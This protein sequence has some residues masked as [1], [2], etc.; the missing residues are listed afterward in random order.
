MDAGPARAHCFKL[1]ASNIGYPRIAELAG[2]SP[3]TVQQLCAGVHPVIR[4]DTAEKLL[5]VPFKP[6]LGT[7][8][9]AHDTWRLLRLLEKEL[10]TPAQIAGLIGAESRMRLGRL[11]RFGKKKA[12][13]W[14]TFCRLGTSL[15]IK[16]A[17]RGT[18]PEDEEGGSDG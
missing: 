3:A 14:R 18:Q 8:V 17:Y 9:A 2:V 1:R 11:G 16:R 6:A 5:A 12:W 10:Y 7:R 15:R 4:K 13:R